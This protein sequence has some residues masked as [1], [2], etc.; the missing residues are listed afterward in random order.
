M[1]QDKAEEKAKMFSMILEAFK[2]Y[3]ET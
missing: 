3:K 1:S 2:Q